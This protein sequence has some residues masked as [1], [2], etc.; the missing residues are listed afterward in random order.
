MGDRVADSPAVFH[1]IRT[2][3]EERYQ[4]GESFPFKQFW[5]IES[6]LSKFTADSFVPTR[7]INIKNKQGE[8]FISR[9]KSWRRERTSN[10]TF[11]LSPHV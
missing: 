7:C 8:N 2:S 6:A 11:Q 3:E 5:G 9:D 10:N 1:H 4:K